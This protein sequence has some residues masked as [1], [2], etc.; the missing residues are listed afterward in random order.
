TIEGYVKLLKK[1]GSVLF[2]QWK[3]GKTNASEKPFQHKD[4]TTGYIYSSKF[5]PSIDNT[6]EDYFGKVGWKIDIK[7]IKGGEELTNEHKKLIMKKDNG[8]P[9]YDKDEYFTSK[10]F[11]MCVENIIAIEPKEV[12]EFVG[13]YTEKFLERQPIQYVFVIDRF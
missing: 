12:T 2:P 4:I 3:I 1:Q 13:Y 11:W 5:R 10:L 9:L 7:W 6:N 8:T